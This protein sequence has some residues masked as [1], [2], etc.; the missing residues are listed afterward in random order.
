LNIIDKLITLGISESDRILGANYV[1]CALTL[2]SE[3]AANTMPWLYH[4]VA[5][6][7]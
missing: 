3:E 6:I 1:L 4:S 5:P 2:V 7:I